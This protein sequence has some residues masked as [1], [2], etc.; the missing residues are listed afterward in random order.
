MEKYTL[1]VEDPTPDTVKAF[2]D[3]M[4]NQHK[5]ER[6]AELEEELRCEKVGTEMSAEKAFW[7]LSDMI[8]GGA[9]E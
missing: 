3:M 4:Y 2:S 9:P 7:M 8:R 6:L 5:L 1:K